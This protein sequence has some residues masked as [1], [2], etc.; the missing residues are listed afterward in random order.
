[1]TDRREFDVVMWG[2]TGFTG[3]LVAEYLTGVPGLRWAIAGRSESKLREVYERLVALNPEAGNDIGV[4]IA[5]S[6]DRASL[7][8]MCART[9]TVASTVGPFA[10]FGAELVAACVAQRTHY[11][12]ITGEPQFVRRMI[13][14]HH[15]AAAGAGVRIVH[16]CGFDSIPSDLGTLCVQ[17]HVIELTG[18]PA[19]RVDTEVRRIKGQAS[20]GTIA[21]IAH[22]IDEAR[23]D[24][25]VRKI[26]GS[27]YS[28]N[29]PDK[30]SGPRVDM[31]YGV[32]KR[33]SGWSAPF[34]MAG[35]NMK[36]V[37]RSHALLHPDADHLDY[38]EVMV[39]GDG[40]KGLRRA[41]GAVAMFAGVGLGLGVK[42]I[43]KLLL[44]RVLPEPGEGPTREQIAAGGF[45]FAVFAQAGDRTFTCTVV[46]PTDPGY[47][48]TSKMLAETA[49]C[50]ARDEAGPETV[51]G[52]VLTPASGLGM[53]LVERLRDAG[54]RF[55][56]S[57]E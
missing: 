3:G 1:M 20:G 35:I 24:P 47:G 11:C 40:F 41:T 9:N 6:R 34:L 45:E 2:A 55:D 54:M 15:D 17:T 52:G 53:A 23:Q 33:D 10:R 22:V 39:F 29:P 37:R 12:D 8:A 19:Q 50:L 21:S 28:L 31:Q 16:C 48:E 36:I 13:D 44:D 38:D 7:D 42:P 49:I 26:A 14:E 46:G 30:R 18:K 5:D 43:R 51:A 56:V 32:G 4:I 25:E 57:V 27:P